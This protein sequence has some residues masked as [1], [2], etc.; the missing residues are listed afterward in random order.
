MKTY[1]RIWSIERA[2]LL[3]ACEICTEHEKDLFM[4][5]KYCEEFEFPYDGIKTIKTC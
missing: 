1:Q 4:Y 3:S 2:T 5:S